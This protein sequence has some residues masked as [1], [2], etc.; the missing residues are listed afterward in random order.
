MIIFISRLL[1]HMFPKQAWLAHYS[2]S[3]WLLLCLLSSTELS[4]SFQKWLHLLSYRNFSAAEIIKI[5]IKSHLLCHTFPKQAWLLLLCL[6]SS[7]CLLSSTTE[8]S[9][10]FQKW[11]RLFSYRNFLGAEII[12]IL[13]KSRLLC[14]IILNKPDYSCSAWLLPFAYLV[15]LLN[16]QFHFKSG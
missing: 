14:H 4:V 3:A 10:S 6:T 12:T 2:C 9:V 16:S 15:A 8:F 1:Y 7:L 13:I 11:L 5:L